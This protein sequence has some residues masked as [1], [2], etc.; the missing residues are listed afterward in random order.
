[1]QDHE[2]RQLRGLKDSL[3]Q[4]KKL[5]KDLDLKDT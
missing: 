4:L 5:E 3:A 1:V 2:L